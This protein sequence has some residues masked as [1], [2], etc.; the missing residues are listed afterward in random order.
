MNAIL[1]PNC[2]TTNQ[3]SANQCFQ[4][5]MPFSSLPPTA[6]VS[7]PIEQTYQAQSMGFQPP[8]PPL[9]APDNETGRKTFFWYRV[10][11][12]AMTALYALV[13][14]VGVFLAAAAPSIPDQRPEETLIIGIVYAALGLIFMAVYGIALFLP[15]KPYNWIVGLVMMALGMTSCCLLPFLIPLLIFWVKPETKAYFGRN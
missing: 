1:C 15:R 3:T 9:F 8:P 7:L 2:R 11:C 14:A 5:G 12:G 13:A 4:C 10:Y 6:Y